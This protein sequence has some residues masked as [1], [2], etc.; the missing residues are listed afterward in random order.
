MLMGFVLSRAVSTRTTK[1]LALCSRQIYTVY[2]DTYRINFGDAILKLWERS[3]KQ[4]Q[5]KQT[6]TSDASVIDETIPGPAVENPTEDSEAPKDQETYKEHYPLLLPFSY[7]AIVEDEKNDV[8][9]TLLEPTLTEVDRQSL[10]ELKN[11]L[12]DE[13]TINTATLKDEH[14]DEFLKI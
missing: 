9:Y 1:I 3:G 12:W 6:A 2:I 8:K 7:A 5:S 14:A 11:I 4:E 13:L 10:T